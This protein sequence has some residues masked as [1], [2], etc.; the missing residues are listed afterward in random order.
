MGAAKA[1]PTG[2]ASVTIAGAI[3][4]VLGAVVATRWFTKRRG[5]VIGVL[6]VASLAACEAMSFST[7]IRVGVKAREVRLFSR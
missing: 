6:S 7:V 5:L 3:A 2:G 1:A 4:N